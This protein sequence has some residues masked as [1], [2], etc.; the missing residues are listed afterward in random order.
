MKLM[1]AALPLSTGALL[2]S[3]FHQLSGGNNGSGWGRSPPR[4]GCAASGNAAANPITTKAS[5]TRNV[6]TATCSAFRLSALQSV[7][8]Q[9][10]IT[11]EAVGPGTAGGRVLGSFQ[12]RCC[13][14]FES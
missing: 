10:I 7:A 14:C 1:N 3:A 6:T 2:M 13:T 12:E 9:I 5:H 11:R 8:V 4:T